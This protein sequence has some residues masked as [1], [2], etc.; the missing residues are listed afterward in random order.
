MDAGAKELTGEV[1]EEVR[2]LA[3]EVRE[4]TSGAIQVIVLA[5]CAAFLGVVLGSILLVLAIV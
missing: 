1:K 2:E 3:G 4:A 5:L